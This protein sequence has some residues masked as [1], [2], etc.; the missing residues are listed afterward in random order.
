MSLKRNNVQLRYE[1]DYKYNSNIP[2]ATCML[3]DTTKKHYTLYR[4][5]PDCMINQK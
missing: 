2:N 5:L 4:V 1:T 3:V